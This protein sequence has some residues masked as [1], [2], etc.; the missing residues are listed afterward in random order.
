MLTGTT[1]PYDRTLGIMRRIVPQRRSGAPKLVARYPAVDLD[2]GTLRGGCFDRVEAGANW[3]A[4]TRWKVG[5]VAEHTW[6]RQPA[7]RGRM[8]S[9]LLRLQRVY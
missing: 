6:L 5:A 1:R 3:W 4:T 7:T 2:G 8:D 9:V